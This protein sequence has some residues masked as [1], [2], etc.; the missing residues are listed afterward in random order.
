M[1]FF[2]KLAKDLEQDFSKL[3]LGGS[4]KKDQ[5]KL[6]PTSPYSGTSRSCVPAEKQTPQFSSD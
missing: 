1:S 6:M 5:S 2:K 4:D 3:G